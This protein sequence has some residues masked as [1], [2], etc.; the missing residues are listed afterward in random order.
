MAR[1]SF[2]FIL[3]WEEALE[4]AGRRAAIEAAGLAAASALIQRPR[5]LAHAFGC[6]KGS[7]EQAH[8]MRGKSRPVCR[9]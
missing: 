2:T 8:R 4:E 6:A 5:R 1:I 7:G 9:M 3:T